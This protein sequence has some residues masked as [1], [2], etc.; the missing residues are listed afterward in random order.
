MS[1]SPILV[2]GATGKT[3]GAV[4]QQL[5]AKGRP[6]RALVRS[7]DAR[8]AALARLGAEIVVADM[9]DP[10]QLFDALRGVERAYFLPVFDRY[11]IQSSAA[12]AVAARQSGLEQLVQMGQWLSN[13]T[14]PALATRQMWLTDQLLATIPSVSHTIIN[15]G[16]FADNFLRVLDFAALL[17][18]F[19]VLSGDGQAAPVSNEDMAR[20]AVAVLTG[21]PAEHDGKSYRPTGPL[22]LS[23]R[24]MAKIVARVVG[25]AVLPV[26]MPFWLFLKV[27]RMQRVDPFQLACYR[28]YMKEMRRGAFAL[29]GGVTDVVRDLTGAPAEDFEVTARR[30]AALPFARQ[31][32]ASRLKTLSNFLITPLWPGYNLDRFSRGAGLPEAPNPTLS[33]DE[34]RWREE[35]RLLMAGSGT[36]AAWSVRDADRMPPPLRLSAVLG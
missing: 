35:R 23:G 17:G 16:M 20:V 13:R 26:D 7:H 8:S 4:A 21:D 19:P 6:V 15:P 32:F 12:F 34:P 29:D 31:R 27:A 36:G 33:I 24:D 22:L 18:V 14:H 2:T 28:F 9:F 11:M 5:L 25:H 1:R 30:Y 3:G 10:D